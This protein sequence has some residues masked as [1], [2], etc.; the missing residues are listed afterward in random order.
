MSTL[1]KVCACFE[2]YKI[3]YAIVGGYAVALLGATRGTVDVDFITRLEEQI[4][5]KIEEAFKSLGFV[6]RL[7]VTAKEVFMFRQE[8]IE[9]RNLIAW[10]FYNPRNP[11]EIVDIIITENLDDFTTVNRTL[12]GQKIKVLSKADLIRMKKKS[13]RPQ[14]LIDIEALEKL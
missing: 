14:D 4:F 12:D 1:Q 9:K 8:Y 10:S 7:P 3:P 11:L 5:L 2:K 13:G 6:S